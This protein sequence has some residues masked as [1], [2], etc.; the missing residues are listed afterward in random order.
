MKDARLEN[1][2]NEVDEILGAL[3]DGLRKT[4][5]AMASILRGVLADSTLLLSELEAALSDAEA[6]LLND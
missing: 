6:A 5:Q 1:P 3:Q 2:G 4:E